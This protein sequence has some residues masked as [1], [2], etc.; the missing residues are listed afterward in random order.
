MNWLIP[1]IGAAFVVAFLP[2]MFANE[3]S[4]LVRVTVY[5]PNKSS[6]ANAAWNGQ[7]LREGHCAVDP[8]E[9]PYGSKIIFQGGECVA[10]DTGPAIV[11]RKAARA[12]GRT[13]A[14][15]NAIVIDRFF[16]TKEKALA[17]A[18]A[19][20]HFMMIRVRTP[21]ATPSSSGVRGT[22]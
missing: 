15:C 2:M 10:V 11:N 1:V 3:H 9:I 17:S 13:P 22:F 5:W 12:C 14:E 4:S 21:D 19:N 8:K 6:G 20:P 7:R 18:E 16:N